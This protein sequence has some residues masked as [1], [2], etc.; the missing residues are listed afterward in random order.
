MPIF[1][2]WQLSDLIVSGP[3]PFGSDA[4]ANASAVGVTTFSIAAEATVQLVTLADDDPN[5]EDGDGDQELTAPTTF[6]GV[7]WGAGASG[8]VETEYAYVIRP[9]GSSDPADNIII[10]VLEFEGGVHGI[11]SSAQLYPG[12]SYQIVGIASDDPVVPYANMAVCFAAGT[13]LATRR[14]PCAVELLQPGDRL[15]TSDNGYAPVQWVGRWRVNG[16][17]ASAPVRFAPGVL[18]NDRAL[19]LSGQHRVLLRPT[20]GPLAGEEVLVAAKSL[21]GL[22][23]IARAP[24]ARV[25]WVHVMLPAHEVIFAENARAESL[26][27]GPQALMMMEPT[28]ARILRKSLSQEPLLALPARPIVPPGKVERMILQHRRGRSPAQSAGLMAGA[29]R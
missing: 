10:Y 12:R 4:T 28:Q 5:F 2:A 20:T 11:A 1:G 14:G 3:D 21:V 27:L 22:P 26:L 13:L 23:G 6:D 25:E 18:C 15:Q 17:G 16:H 7:T 8:E 9:V 24:C 19:F 29:G